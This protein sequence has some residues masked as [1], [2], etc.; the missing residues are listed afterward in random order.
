MNNEELKQKI[1]TLTDKAEFSEEGSEFLN[2]IIPPEALHSLASSLK[3]DNDTKFDFLF[4]LSGVDWITHLMTVYHLTSTELK[5]TLVL[6]V[7]IHDRENPE[8]D[9]VCDLWRTA[10]FHEREVYDLFGIKFRNHPDL[11]RI[12]LDDDWKGFPL[13]KDYKDEVNIVEF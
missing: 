12:L 11:R 2:V 5:H 1:N 8:V 4:C 13:R 3:F 6:K 9:T 10:E 7:K